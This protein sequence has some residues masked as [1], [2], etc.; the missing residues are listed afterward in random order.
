MNHM[1]PKPLQVDLPGSSTLFILGLTSARPMGRV[2]REQCE[3][4]HPRIHM[5]P[6]RVASFP[7]ADAQTPM[8][9]HRRHHESSECPNG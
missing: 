7:S 9:R 4:V 2:M 5:D 3:M 1:N 8:V 6:V